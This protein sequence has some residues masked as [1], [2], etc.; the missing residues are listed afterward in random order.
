MVVTWTRPP[1]LMT[2]TLT[3]KLSQDVCV[4][5]CE[6]TNTKLP[7]YRG[8]RLGRDSVCDSAR[9]LSYRE[10][11]SSSPLHIASEIYKESF[12]FRNK[13]TEWT[14][15]RRLESR[16]PG[17]TQNALNAGRSCSRLYSQPLG[18]QR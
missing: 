4:C 8:A 17:N 7:S 5:E 10:T 11:L 18:E 1:G 6:Y 12:Q 13:M 3:F 14:M 16:W 9:P 2:G 15:D